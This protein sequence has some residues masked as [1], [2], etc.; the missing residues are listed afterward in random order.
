MAQKATVKSPAKV[1]ETE[2]KEKALKTAMEQIEKQFGKGA[3]MRLGENVG[4]NENS[5]DLRTGIVG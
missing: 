2:G 4:M 3:I 5:R 1:S